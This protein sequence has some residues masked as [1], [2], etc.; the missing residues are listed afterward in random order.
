MPK[1]FPVTWQ[2]IHLTAKA[3]AWKIEDKG[4][5][6]GVIGITRGGMVPA[7]IVAC[8]LDIKMLDTLCI[9]SYDFNTHQQT[10][11]S[12]LKKPDGVGNGEGWI[13]VDD[14]VDTGKT[15]EVARK[16]FPKALYVALYAKPQGKPMTDVFV[17]DVSQDTWIYL[18]WDDLSFPQHIHDQIGQHLNSLKNE[19]PK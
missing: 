1:D 17:T 10:E 18:P 6:K 8:E 5:F 13:I 7:T 9:T 14:L 11:A 2:D 16:I 4:P 15:F 3:L 12:I 19:R